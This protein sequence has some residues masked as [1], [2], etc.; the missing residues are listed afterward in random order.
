MIVGIHWVD[1]CNKEVGGISR[2]R[3]VNQGVLEWSIL[4]QE[5]YLYT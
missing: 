1:L 4:I 3:E 2:V 5:K